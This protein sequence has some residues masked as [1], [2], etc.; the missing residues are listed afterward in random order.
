MVFA[1]LVVKIELINYDR[2]SQPWMC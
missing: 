2:C 1:M